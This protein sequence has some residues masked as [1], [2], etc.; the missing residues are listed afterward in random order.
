[1]PDSGTHPNAYFLD[2]FNVYSSLA[3]ASKAQVEG[4]SSKDGEKVLQKAL[5]KTEKL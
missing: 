5:K 2:W 3:C 4:F 1:M